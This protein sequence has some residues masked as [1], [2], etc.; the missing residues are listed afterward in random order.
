[1][2]SSSGLFVLKTPAESM[3]P[4]LGQ[5][6]FRIVHQL[7][8]RFSGS[9]VLRTSPRMEIM[10]G[11]LALMGL[12]IVSALKVEESQL[13][14]FGMLWGL[15]ALLGGAIVC[16]LGGSEQIQPLSFAEQ[17]QVETLLNEVGFPN[18][19]WDISKTEVRFFRKVSQDR[20]PREI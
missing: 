11:G 19:V 13:V 1:M 4:E 14:G 16:L 8:R 2:S 12:M 10:M 18:Y 5:S 17:N 7:N 9:R 15:V 20:S 3:P 6:V